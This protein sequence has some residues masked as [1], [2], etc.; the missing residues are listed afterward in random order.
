[1]GVSTS[2][3]RGIYRR[4][5]KGE[6]AESF[7]TSFHGFSTEMRPD[8][9]RIICPIGVE[10]RWLQCKHQLLPFQETLSCET[11]TRREHLFIKL[12]H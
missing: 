1:M 3:D 4:Q 12:N 7:P 11:F 9:I 2:K 10:I 8:R 6:T 5:L